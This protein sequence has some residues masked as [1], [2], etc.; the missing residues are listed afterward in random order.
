MS[1]A[2][3]HSSAST[4]VTRPIQSDDSAGV[5]N[6]T[7]S[8]GRGRLPLGKPD[9]AGTLVVGQPATAL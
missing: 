2:G 9:G 5:R 8:L 1:H 6:G 3:R 7:G 4:D